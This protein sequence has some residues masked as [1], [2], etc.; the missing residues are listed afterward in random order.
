MAIAL[1]VCFLLLI[2]L[3]VS[4]FFLWVEVKAMGKS[5]HQ[6]QYMNIPTQDFQKMT[7]E[8]KEKLNKPY[9]DN[10]M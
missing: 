3:S 10:V 4:Q 5:T 1:G 7:E 8:L 9:F 2:I 6:V